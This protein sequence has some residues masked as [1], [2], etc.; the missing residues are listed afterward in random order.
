MGG[1]GGGGGQR[2]K[3]PPFSQKMED[4]KI[5]VK[6]LFIPK[7]VL[8]MTPY[9]M[10]PKIEKLVITLFDFLSQQNFHFTNFERIL[11]EFGGQMQK[12]L[13]LAV[14]I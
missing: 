13:G 12:G 9:L 4:N 14:P 3:I 10:L 1:G 8:L 2:G 7:N 6:L 11:F 5:R